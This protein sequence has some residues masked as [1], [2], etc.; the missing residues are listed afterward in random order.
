VRLQFAKQGFGNVV[1]LQ[2]QSLGRCPKGVAFLTGPLGA[3][4]PLGY[5]WRKGKRRLAKFE[6]QFPEGLEFVARAMR[7]GHAFSVS[8]EMLHREFDEPLAGPAF[9]VATIGY[10]LFVLQD[11]VLTGL[12]RT[13]WVPV[14]NAAFSVAKVGL[15]VLLATALPEHGVFVSWLLPVVVAVV[16]V[17]GLLFGWAIPRHERIEP[18]IGQGIGCGTA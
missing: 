5:V 16:V 18:M 12:R 2:N 11:G 15:V 7:A 8:L 3:A 17:G 6:T 14:E 13:A 1:A 10:A 9:I 4:A